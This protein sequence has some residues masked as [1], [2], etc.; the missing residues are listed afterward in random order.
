MTNLPD[1]ILNEYAVVRVQMDALSDEFI[2][3]LLKEPKKVINVHRKPGRKMHHDEVNYDISC[4][5]GKN[6]YTLVIRQSRMH[7]SNY[8]CGLRWQSPSSQEVVLVR[9]NGDGHAHRNHLEKETI[10]YKNHIQKATERYMKAGKKAEQYA[11]ETD[12]YHNLQGALRCL[13]E[14]CNISGLPQI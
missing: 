1:I 13:A 6:F 12:R 10:E 14:D 4:K 5:D 7:P 3:K 8:S 9:Y 11:I 2:D